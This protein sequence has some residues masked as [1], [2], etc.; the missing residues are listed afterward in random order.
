MSQTQQLYRDLATVSYRIH[1]KGNRV[2]V[3]KY[4]GEADYS[5]EVEKTFAK[6]KQGAV[7]SWQL[8]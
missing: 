4:D 1:I 2:R 8:P 5:A 3:S 6:F 7:K